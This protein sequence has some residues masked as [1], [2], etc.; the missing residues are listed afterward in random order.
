MLILAYLCYLYIYYGLLLRD[1]DVKLYSRDMDGVQDIIYT[2]D[3][4]QT[5]EAIDSIVFAWSNSDGRTWGLEVI[6]YG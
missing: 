6:Y 5:F 2:F 1:I 4:L 3:S